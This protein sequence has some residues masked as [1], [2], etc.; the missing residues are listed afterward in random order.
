[1]LCDLASQEDIRRFADEFRSRYSTLS[2]LINNAGVLSSRRQLTE[3]GWE[4]NFGVNYLSHFLLSNLL[5]DL[6]IKSQGRIIT[7]S[8]VAHKIGRIHFEDVNLTDGYG[9][10]RA[11]SQSKLANILFTYE[12]G[13]RL[14]GTG[15]TANCLHPGV[16]ATNII[17]DRQTGF[18]SLTARLMKH[19]FISP[20]QGAETAI[21]LAS[22]PE[23]QG[24]SGKYFSR[25][26][27]IAS[28]ALS[29]DLVTA[30][31]LWNIS[32]QMTGLAPSPAVMELVPVN[33]T[34]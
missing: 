27:P 24:I 17:V 3:D 30:E 14:Q 8:S 2:V 34:I 20:E 4:L 26:G 25:K 1:M 9:W 15:A 11:Y 22:S 19:F 18:G 32:E 10:L 13:R 29:Y 33:A 7:L 16:V 6:I 23:V 5:L 21:F 28:S 31:L 12:L